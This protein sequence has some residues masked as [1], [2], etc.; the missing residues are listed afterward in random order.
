[1]KS[2]LFQRQAGNGHKPIHSDLTYDMDHLPPSDPA[3]VNQPQVIEER[4]RLF[5]AWVLEQAMKGD[6]WTFGPIQPEM[7]ASMLL[8]CPIWKAEHQAYSVRTKETI[9]KGIFGALQHYQDHAVETGKT[10]NRASKG[11][12]RFRGLHVVVE[13]PEGSTRSGTD[14]KGEKWE[15]KMLHD[16]GYLKGIPAADGDDLDCYVADDEGSDLVFVIEQLKGDGTFDEHKALLG[17][18]DQGAALK[19]YLSHMPD[20]WHQF[21]PL[22][23]YSIGEFREKWI[24]MPQAKTA[25][26]AVLPK[27]DTVW[28]ELAEGELQSVPALT[29]SI[30]GLSP[31]QIA[32]KLPEGGLQGTKIP[33]GTTI[34]IPVPGPYKTSEE[35]LKAYMD[36]KVDETKR[37]DPEFFH[38]M[39]GAEALLAHV[40]GRFH[41]S[42]QPIARLAARITSAR[43]TA[44]IMTQPTIQEHGGE[45]TIT[46][47]DSEVNAHVL[48][49]RSQA[50]IGDIFVAPG[51]RRQGVGTR[52]MLALCQWCKENGVKFITGIDVSEGGASGLIRQKLPGETVTMSRKQDVNDSRSGADVFPDATDSLKEVLQNYVPDPKGSVLV[53]RL[54]KLLR[55]GKIAFHTARPETGSE[56]NSRLKDALGQTEHKTAAEE[57]ASTGEHGETTD[58]SGQFYGEQGAG[59]LICAESTGRCLF[60]KRSEFVNEPHEWGVWGGAL[61]GEEDPLA[62]ATREV[63][64]ETGYEGPLRL[65]EA[66]VYTKDDFRY[67]T[68]V[69]FVPDEFAPKLNWETEDHAWARLDEHPEPLHFGIKEAMPGIEKVLNGPAAKTAKQIKD[70]TL[71][72]RY[73]LTPVQVQQARA[74]DPTGDFTEWVAQGI[75]SGE[76]DPLKDGEPMKTA[77][78]TFRDVREMPGFR[79]PKLI[80][81]YSPS[82]LIQTMSEPISDSVPDEHLADLMEQAESN[83]ATNFEGFVVFLKQHLGADLGALL[84]NA[85]GWAGLR[86]RWDRNH[87]K[88]DAHLSMEEQRISPR[89]PFGARATEDPNGPDKLQPGY[90]VM[91]RDEKAMAKNAAIMKQYPNFKGIRARNPKVIIE[92]MI[93]E[94]VG[95]LLWL[96]DHWNP[97]LKDRSAAWYVGG[98]RLVHR[99]SQ[100]FGIDPHKVA[101]VMAA[102]SPQ[103]HWFENVSLGERVIGILAQHLDDPWTPAMTKNALSW[104]D[105][106]DGGD[107]G[108]EDEADAVEPMSVMVPKLEGKT[109]R[110]LKSEGDT[111]GM[112]IFI[113]AY[114]TVYNPKKC[115]SVSPEGEFGDWYRSDTTGKPVALKWQSFGAISKAIQVLEAPTVKEISDLVG[116]NHK[117]RSFYNNLIAPHS[118]GGDVTIDTHAVAAALFRPLS[119]AN[120]EVYH[121]FGSGVAGKAAVPYRPASVDPKTGKKIKERK[122]K[123]ATKAVPGPANSA[124]TGST[125]TYGIYAEAYRRAAKERGI[126][127]REMQSITWE[128]VRGLFGIE[129]KGTKGKDTQAAINQTWLDYNKGAMDGDA[130]RDHI[131]G[132]V[133]G[134]KDPSW[135][136]PH[137]SGAEVARDSSYETELSG[138]VD[139]GPGPGQPGP[140]TGARAASRTASSIQPGRRTAGGSADIWPTAWI[141]PQGTFNLCDDHE[142]WA[143]KKLGGGPLGLTTWS[144]KLK[145]KGWMRCGEYEGVTYVDADVWTTKTL[146]NAQ[147]LVSTRPEFRT[148][149]IL[150]AAPNMEVEIPYDEFM[151][152][153]KPTE[154]RRYKFARLFKRAGIDWAARWE[155][156]KERRGNI[157]EDIVADRKKLTT[158]QLPT[159]AAAAPLKTG[160]QVT[161]TLPPKLAPHLKAPGGLSSAR[162]WH[163]KVWLGNSGTKDHT[164]VTAIAF[165]AATGTIVPIA[166]SDEHQNG[167]ELIQWMERKNMIPA[168]QWRIIFLGVNFVDPGNVEQ[169][170]KDLAAFKAWLQMGGVNT[171][172]RSRYVNPGFLVSMKDF[173]A[174]KGNVQPNH[175]GGVIAPAGARVIKALDELSALYTRM[176]SNQRVNDKALYRAAAAC[177]D[178]FDHIRYAYILSYAKIQEAEKA[179]GDLGAGG[180]PAEFER[181]IFAFDGLKNQVHNALRKFGDN[182]FKDNDLREAF[183]DCALAKQEFDRMGNAPAPKQALLF[184][185]KRV[186]KST[187]LLVTVDVAKVEASYSQD[188]N[189]YV[190]PNGSGAAIGKR[191]E[192]F[193]TWLAE[194]PDTPIDPP[195][196]GLGPSGNVVFGDGRHRWAVLRD[197]GEKRIAVMIPPEEFKTFQERYGAQKENGVANTGSRAP[198]EALA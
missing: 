89:K 70:Q 34:I 61:D 62:A 28:G 21:G 2:K 189:F 48:K 157:P 128:A 27:S 165:D 155:R 156:L 19:G 195:I 105:E 45:L 129:F 141:S 108:A 51:E 99:Y 168:L 192:T 59:A 164:E 20:G 100:K 136:R 86:S 174:A 133:G 193:E 75:A 80:D 119:S 114:D 91:A 64:E 194:N 35:A 41:I 88:E 5:T 18:P 38:F 47:G 112:A 159:T 56:F 3:K 173:V 130:A 111:L 11:T 102:L 113:R 81:G 12:Y 144:D 151:A 139:A 191:Y 68:F 92:A 54:A 97:E 126:L 16:Y 49:D 1:M 10:A 181:A 95:N 55:A 87:A 23:V 58:K 190:G 121:N 169:T 140:G 180:D 8:T 83:G 43:R 29:D 65:E 184:Q 93:Q 122:A 37:C 25:S 182:Q 60:P 44:A 13:F 167:W 96:H 79:D 131:A 84:R 78:E 158:I 103:K 176:H 109:L 138:P 67:T 31:D 143:S 160:A 7:V 9:L 72:S 24:Q 63:R 198:Q 50:I 186:W 117:V 26:W 196:M 183:G 118:E 82:E 14:P 77:L 17:F 132:L 178:A 106:G 149:V 73:G 172:V 6:D 40:S 110:Q 152:L 142:A 127:P 175:D 137:R 66:Y 170:Q 162:Q 76:I 154:F 57:G 98:N 15:R 161:W 32:L 74:I 179:L 116:A 53:T 188:G 33:D 134:I 30:T 163:T 90:E 115:R 69:G 94:M 185:P 177:M 145:A 101:G 146:A 42:I 153:N 36:C 46:M 150:V 148:K 71:V 147:T 171:A 135:A 125:G 104:K 107:A 39:E 166:G 187:S 120:T 123:P 4:T 197:L 85:D 124:I 52:M 22:R